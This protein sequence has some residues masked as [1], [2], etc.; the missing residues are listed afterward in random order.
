MAGQPQA[1]SVLQPAR[2]PSIAGP[3][4]TVTPPSLHLL[5]LQEKHLQ[6]PHTVPPVESVFMCHL[7]CINRPRILEEHDPNLSQFLFL[8][9]NLEVYAMQEVIVSQVLS[10]NSEHFAP[11]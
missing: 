3:A 5:H 7:L 4:S 8:F 10:I 9:L 11:L 6:R 1:A 2:S